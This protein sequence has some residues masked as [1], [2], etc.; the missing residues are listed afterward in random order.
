MEK[1]YF[2]YVI[3]YKTINNEYRQL[4][5]EVDD[6][7]E[8]YA[9]LLQ[10]G[11]NELQLHGINY[12]QIMEIT[13]C[14]LHYGDASSSDMPVF[15]A[16]IQKVWVRVKNCEDPILGWIPGYLRYDDSVETAFGTLCNPEDPLNDIRNWDNPPF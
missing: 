16:F 15:M 8:N 1:K 6:S 5:L 3:V 9:E 13:P 12:L 4:L 14:N 10:R 11:H 2:I 7:C